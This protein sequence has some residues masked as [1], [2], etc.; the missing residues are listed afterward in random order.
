MKTELRAVIGEVDTY[1]VV[2]Q[3]SNEQ[4]IKYASLRGGCQFTV[5]VF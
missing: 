1:S 3:G 4:N 5:Q 2:V